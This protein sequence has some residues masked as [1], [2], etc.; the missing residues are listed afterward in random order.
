ME[1]RYSGYELKFHAMGGN[2]Q[3]LFVVDC[4]ALKVEVPKFFGK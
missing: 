1:L 2:G 3:W 4:T